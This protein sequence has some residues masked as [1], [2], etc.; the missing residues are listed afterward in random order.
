MNIN[1][2]SYIHSGLPKIWN[3]EKTLHLVQK[4]LKILEF[5]T[6]LHEKK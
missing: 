2:I 4:S 6:I 1:I 5:L 3:P